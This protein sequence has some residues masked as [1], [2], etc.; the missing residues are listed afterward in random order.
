MKRETLVKQFQSLLEAR[1]KPPEYPIAMLFVIHK[2]SEERMTSLLNEMPAFSQVYKTKI[3][4]AYRDI[5]RNINDDCGVLC[6]DLL[7]KIQMHELR[8]SKR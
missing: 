8:N 2:Y 4:N 6:T 5:E 3:Q 1:F 7:T